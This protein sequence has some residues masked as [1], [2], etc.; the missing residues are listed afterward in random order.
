MFENYTFMFQLYSETLGGLVE[1]RKLF[2]KM[3][4]SI[5]FPDQYNYE[6]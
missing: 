3:A 2:D 5:V 6:L 1:N 4:N